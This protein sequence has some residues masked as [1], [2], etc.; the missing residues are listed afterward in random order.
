MSRAVPVSALV[1]D[2]D[3]YPRASVD[4][5]HIADMVRAMEADIALPA[6]VVDRASKRIVDGWHRCRAV[7]RFGG[8]EAKI[9]VDF[10]DYPDEVSLYADAVRLNADHGRKLTRWDHARIKLRATELGIA[11][12]QVAVLIH[13]PVDYVTAKLH[14]A[15]HRTNGGTEQVAL[16]RTLEHLDG[17]VLT[18]AQYVANQHASGW[19][20]TFHAR[21]LCELIAADALK[22][23]DDETE[24]LRSLLGLLEGLGL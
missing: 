3:L 5:T 13:R 15:V 20:A 1:E 4:S 12:T 6:I 23:S 16:K 9:Q 11:P 22:G 2:Y 18:E 24:A 17:A 21:Q 14:V 7:R 19:S 10:R 8:D